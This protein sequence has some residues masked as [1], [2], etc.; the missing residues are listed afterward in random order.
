MLQDKL[1]VGCGTSGQLIIFNQETLD[2]IDTLRVSCR[3][4]SKLVA[5]DNR[6]WAG[7]KNG[8]LHVFNSET[9][10]K[11]KDLEAH[12][13]AI[14]SMCTADSQYII[15]GSGSRDGKVAIW[16]ANFVSS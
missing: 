13:D 7:S 3:G 8:R 1:W 14:R 4:I 10:R 5:V 6:I 2:V 15:S 12:E 11:E 9:F 16:K